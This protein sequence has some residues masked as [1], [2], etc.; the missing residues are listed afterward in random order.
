[1]R[2]SKSPLGEWIWALHSGLIDLN[3]VASEQGGRGSK[4]HSSRGW[5]TMK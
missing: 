1:M 5:R 2:W 3:N 4:E